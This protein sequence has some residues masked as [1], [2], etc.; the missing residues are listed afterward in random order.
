MWDNTRVFVAEPTGM[1]G[2]AIVRALGRRGVEG[3]ILDG[4]HLHLTDAAAVGRF[5]AD[6]RP[7]HVFLAAGK[8]G[9]ILANQRFPADLMLNNLRVLT[10]VIGSAFQQGVQKLLYLGSACLYPRDCPQPMEERMLLTGPFEPTNE[11][12][13]VAKLAG[14]KLCQAIH[15]Q[16]GRSFIAAIP[17]NVY[18]PHDEFDPDNAHVIGALIHRI[19]AAKREGRRQVDIWGSGRP[20]REFLYSDDL[21]EACVFLMERYDGAEPVNVAGGSD[22]SI[23]ELAEQIRDALD[24]R[25]ELKFDTSK[26]DGMPNKSLDGRRMAEIGWR[27]TVPF[28]D[29]LRRTCAWYERHHF[30]TLPD[31]APVSCQ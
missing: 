21:G 11:A 3:Q 27:P 6:E 26:P 22:V 15:N 14:L 31:K 2:R 7:T 20:R 18:G 30:T 16:Y 1:M 9:G 10:N 8:K 5:F 25:G 29:G 12:Y 13:S 17:T 19:S 23:R 4:G 24:Y 28:A